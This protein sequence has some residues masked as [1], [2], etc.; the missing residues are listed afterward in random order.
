MANRIVVCLK[1]PI[2]KRKRFQTAFYDGVLQVNWQSVSVYIY[3]QSS[4]LSQKKPQRHFSIITTPAPST[5]Y[6]T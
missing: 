1:M 2:N 4:L 5:Y 6:Q 3:W